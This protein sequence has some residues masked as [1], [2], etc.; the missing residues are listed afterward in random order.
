MDD[1]IN[2]LGRGPEG[3]SANRTL[4]NVG[5]QYGLVALSRGQITAEQFVELNERI[6]GYDVDGNIVATR[7]EAH[8]APFD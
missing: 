3:S 7:T 1:N 6:G 5:V 2:I 4:D 8:S